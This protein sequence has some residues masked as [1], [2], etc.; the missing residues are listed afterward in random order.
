MRVELVKG[1][2]VKVRAEPVK[3]LRVKV[4]WTNLAPAVLVVIAK[5]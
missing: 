3:G 4:R 2:R 5:H 1:L